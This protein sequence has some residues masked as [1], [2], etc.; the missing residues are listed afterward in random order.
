MEVIIPSRV[1]YS[2]HYSIDRYCTCFTGHYSCA[3]RRDELPVERRPG[4]DRPISHDYSVDCYVEIVVCLLPDYPLRLS[5]YL[6]GL[7][8]D[9]SDIAL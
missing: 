6:F 4:F 2:F 3:V 9:S 7:M 5:D 1:C 8:I